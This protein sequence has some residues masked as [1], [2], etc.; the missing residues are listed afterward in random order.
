LVA[1]VPLDLVDA[2]TGEVRLGC[3]L[4]EF[5]KLDRAEATEFVP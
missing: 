5:E 4:T 1:W 2:T 3:T